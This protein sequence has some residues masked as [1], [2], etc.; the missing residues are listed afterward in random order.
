MLTIYM[1]ILYK[2]LTHKIE[3]SLFI[4]ALHIYKQKPWKTK[5]YMQKHNST[6]SYNT[7]QTT[8]HDTA[9]WKEKKNALR[10]YKTNTFRGYLESLGSKITLEFPKINPWQFKNTGS[11][12]EN[13]VNVKLVKQHAVGS[14]L[15]IPDMYMR[16]VSEDLPI[17]T[18]SISLELMPYFPLLVSY[19]LL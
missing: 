9:N 10:T 1:S 5:Q 6:K 4:Q 15:L 13:K 14:I 12:S 2:N 16:G 18:V 7:E 8:E 17:W 11:N 3:N 19:F